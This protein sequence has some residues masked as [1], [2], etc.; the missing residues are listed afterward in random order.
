M[1]VF[2]LYKATEATIKIKRIVFAENVEQASSR[3]LRSKVLYSTS[4]NTKSQELLILSAL[5]SLTV[6]SISV[7]MRPCRVMTVS[8]GFFLVINVYTIR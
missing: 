2:W 6:L 7:M 1:N 4:N 3:E 8:D 5:L